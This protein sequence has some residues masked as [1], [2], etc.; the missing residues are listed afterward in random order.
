MVTVSISFLSLGSNLGDRLAHLT[1]AINQLANNPQ[2][3]I[4]KVSSVYQT[5]PVGGPTQDDFLN[6]VVKIETEM[7]PKQLLAFVQSIENA[8][9]R[10][11]DIRWGPRTLD[12]DVLSYDDLVSLDEELTLPHPRIAQ[13]AFVLVPLF[14]IEPYGQISGLGQIAQLYNQI[15]K[16][17]VQLNSDMKLPEGN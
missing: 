6:A 14:E 2:I 1:A 17:D 5:K 10:T 7:L 8:Q 9:N 11:R 15:P 4:L 12:I 3:Q 13:R 16:D